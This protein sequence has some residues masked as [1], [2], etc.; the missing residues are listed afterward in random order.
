MALLEKYLFVKRSTLPNA[1]KGLFTK[2][3]I[4][5]GTRIVEYKGRIGTW[6]EASSNGHSS[7]Y[8]LYVKRDHV[9]DAE[10]YKK[11]IGRFANDAVGFMRR[12]G[13]NN[14][15][16]YE[17]DGLQIFITAKKDIEP[18]SEILVGY[19]KEY[20]QAMRYNNR[21]D[22]EEKISRS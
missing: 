7:R 6:R 19:G 2:K 13:L 16:Y 10:P 20:W 15:A 8:V 1:G 22:R 9:I 17:Q 18:G 12:K 14:N 11:A 3:F 4:P 21:L 5:K